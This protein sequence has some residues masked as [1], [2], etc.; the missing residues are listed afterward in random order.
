MK[1]FTLIALTL[2]LC[3]GMM[4]GCGEKEVLNPDSSA[5][6]GFRLKNTVI[7]LT[8]KGYAYQLCDET[9]GVTFR[10]DD[11]TVATFQNGVVTAVG[12]GTTTVSAKRGGETLQCTVN[13]Q[14]AGTSVSTEI[15]E[16]TADSQ[17]VPETTET[18]VPDESVSGESA[19]VE[20]EAPVGTGGKRD[21]VKG[22][23]ATANVDSSFFD[24]AV[25][26]GDSVSLKLSYYAPASGELGKAQFLV[27]GSYS[28]E[29]A[30]R[31][32]MLLPYQGQQMKFS[33]AIAATGA[34]K[35]FIMLGLND[36]NLDSLENI[37]SKWDA[38]INAVLKKVPDAK[39]YIESATPVYT[40][41]E[42]GNINN[43]YMDQ[44][45]AA[46]KDFADSKG[47]HFI[48]INSYMKDSTGGLAA[49]YCSDEYVHVTDAGVQTWIKVLKASV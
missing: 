7:N 9:D 13:C 12:E 2:L 26:V 31:D 22:A 21:P 41:A 47:Y 11:E 29:H 32:T 36:V 17:P 8:T 14:F 10:S 3:A 5:S 43:P 33:D 27:A 35:V 1:R 15:P 49:P 40:G 20:T 4:A 18:T 30:Y 42:Q 48:D 44:L 6:V 34:K 19:P 38:E 37:I 23:P 45:N 46:L 25:F 24:D 39:I 28:M 16:E